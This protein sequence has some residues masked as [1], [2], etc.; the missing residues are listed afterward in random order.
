MTKEIYQQILDQNIPLAVIGLGYVGLPIAVSFSKKVKVIGFDIDRNKIEDLRNGIDISGEVNDEEI[1][2]CSVVFTSDPNDLKEAKFYVIAVPTPVMEGNVPD[3]T[4]VVK[5]SE[6]VAK[7]M[8]HGS[9]IVYESTVYP[10]VTEE[11][12]VPILEKYS[13]LQS[14]KDFYYGYSPERINPGDQVNTLENI[15]K[16]VSGNNEEALDL[17]ANVYSLVIRAGVFK[18]QSIQVAEAAK[19]VENAQR[20][21]NIAFL[22]EVSM[23]F[24]Q[25]GIDTQEVLN[26]AGTKWN[27]IPFKPGLVGG[28]CIGIDPYYLTY[29]AEENGYSSKIIMAGRQ[30]NNGMGAYISQHI[31][32]QMVRLKMDSTNLKVGILGITFKEDCPDIRNT[33]VKDIIDELKAYNIHPLV[34]DPLADQEY[35]QKEYD[36]DLCEMEDMKN[37]NIIVIAVPHQLF[38]E[39]D[40]ADFERMFDRTQPKLLI[41]I[42]GAYNKEEFQENGYYYW[43]L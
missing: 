16:V 2:N 33:K 31:I 12:C 15:V 27:F 5:A 6:L 19:V 43:R 20:D 37:M 3:L 24:H 40:I 8:P 11:V 34:M 4:Y 9:T 13:G 30:I 39:M 7:Q 35:V 22:N 38:R 1:Q 17:I 10:G 14:D 25:M 23:M 42:K 36:I 41:D 21:I 28:H 32:K 26:A 18:A 29:R